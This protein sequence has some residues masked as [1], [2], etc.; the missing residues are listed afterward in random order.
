MK[1]F[2]AGAWT[3]KPK[4]IEVRNPFDNSV[5]DTVPK[6]DAADVERAL[7]YAERGAKVMAKLTGYER[8]KILRQAADLMAAR[9]EELGRTISSE[10]GKIIAEGRGE[11]NRAVETVMGSAEEAKRI[12]GETVPLDGDPSGNKKLGFTLRVPCGVVAAISPFNFPLNLVSHKVGPALAAGNSVIVK[13]ASDTP[14][15]ALKLTEILLE[16]GLP[17]E[18]IQ[19][20][21]GP[22]GEIGDTLVADRRVRKV[23]F[24]G[25]R[26]IGDRICRM[27]GIKKVTMELGS[28][29]PLI[30]MPDADLDKVAVAVVATGYAN[31][32]QACISTQRVLTSKKI[33]GDLLGAL[34]PKVEALATGNQLDEKTKVGP[35]VKES[36][37][38]RVEDW[39]GEAV[40]G[41]AR[42][43]AGGGRRGAI[44][45]P[46]VVAD[47]K[48]EMRI[49]RD[50]LFGPAVAVTPFDTI[51]DAIA[52]ANDSVY[53]L[54]AG[55]FTENVEWA[56]KFAREV[57]AGNL[58]VNWGP[59][60][61]VDLMP[62]GGLKDSGFGKEGPR[63]AVE[64]MT[65][66]KMVV[67]HLSS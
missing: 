3:D 38:A 35:M 30:V 10:E 54:A 60:W 67:F 58:H 50:E 1:M 14:L 45:I 66:L 20:I 47:V 53:G 37:A 8:W 62:Y 49:S 7:T 32:G 29:S 28:N 42:L 11:A 56:M 12:H 33:Y 55:I 51:E 40:A 41:G 24:T 31:A 2:L 46:A 6:G 17:P 26:E 63:Y 4:K 15:S 64:E 25:S 34:K 39:I 36:E 19:C 21:T 18:G 16:A 43:A 57:E 44:Y 23:T 5:I 9:N 59:Q 22:G 13:P 61:R 27:A 48:P 52:L 65:E